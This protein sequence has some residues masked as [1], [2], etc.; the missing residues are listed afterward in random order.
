MTEPEGRS[1]LRLVSRLGFELIVVF[2]G[3]YGAFALSNYGA[4]R[5][6]SER[7]QQMQAALVQE[8][9]GIIAN[10]GNAAREVRSMLAAFDSAYAAGGSPPPI[11]MLEP[12]R[13][14]NH[15][16]EITLASGG[17][18]LME[19]STAFELSQFYN[20]LNL[21]F[22]QLE[23]LRQLSESTILPSLDLGPDEFYESP[24]R[25]RAKY[26]W[27]LSGLR[28]LQELAERTTTMGEGLVRKLSVCTGEASGCAEGG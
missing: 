10:T 25:L 24:G 1:L 3:V 21:G 20:E 13:I 14:Q 4:E 6:A 2:V 15:M 26:I 8:I 18:D 23:Q 27:Y 5:E 12:V 28:S 22:A 11:P 17:L 16:W 7:R 9:E 19:V